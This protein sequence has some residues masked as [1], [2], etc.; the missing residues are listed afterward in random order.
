MPGRRSCDD[1][2]HCRS[3]EDSLAIFD[4]RPKS[5][6]DRADTVAS[7]M[8]ARLCWIAFATNLTTHQGESVRHEN[9]SFTSSTDREDAALVYLRGLPMSIVQHCQRTL[10]GKG[11]LFQDFPP[12]R[13]PRAT[14]P[15]TLLLRA[16]LSRE[17]VL[18]VLGPHVLKV[19]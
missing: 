14:S 9:L 2:A 1:D 11:G 13:V 3:P 7:C 5:R 6:T 4:L 15:L 17:G 18:R 12:P 19:M 16:D 8:K 10:G